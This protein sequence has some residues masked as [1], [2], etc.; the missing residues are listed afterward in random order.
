MN[1]KFLSDSKFVD[2]L[3]LM[4]D[5]AHERWN[6]LVDH[7]TGEKVGQNIHKNEITI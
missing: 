3:V 5:N 1:G 6:I 2:N 4:T 7:K